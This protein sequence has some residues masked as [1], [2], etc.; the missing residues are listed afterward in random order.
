M[1][2]FFRITDALFLSCMQ[3]GI[4]AAPAETKSNCLKTVRLFIWITNVVNQK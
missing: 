2:K 1:E 3:A 4:S